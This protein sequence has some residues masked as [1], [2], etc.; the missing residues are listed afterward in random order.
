MNVCIVG[1]GAIGPIHAEA[2]SKLSGVNIYGICDIVKERADEAAKK[3]SAKAFYDFDECLLDE[4][5]D[6]IHVCTPHYLH[7]EMIT[8]AVSRNKQVVCEKPITMTGEEFSSLMRDFDTSR[9]YPVFQNRKN[10]CIEYLAERIGTDKS[11]GRLRGVKGIATWVR[12]ADYYNADAW[13]GTKKY[14]GGGV[15]INQTIH[16]LDLMLLFGGKVSSVCSSA[17]NKS[18]QGVIEVEDTLDARIEF[19][20]GAV[21]V[22][23]AT[24]GYAEN[25]P[26]QLE[27]V[28]ENK[29]F[30]YYRGSLYEDGNLVCSDSGAS[31]GKDYWGSGH[32]R[33][34]HDI[35][36]TDSPLT[37]AETRETMELMF[38]IYDRANK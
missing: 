20:S 25:T 35:Y 32:A 30:V 16:L 21:G 28:F 22:F 8:K 7:Y 23:F 19:E 26:F 33:I 5:I 10:A 36:E 27:L 38:K 31:P 29:V 2:L 15:L 14:E 18:L 9:V 34:M 1:F 12:G 24:N 13:R 3:Y 6:S 37:L 17:S 11:L 4:N